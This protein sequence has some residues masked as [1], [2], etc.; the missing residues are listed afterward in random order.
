MAN[1][2]E[3]FPQFSVLSEQIIN[4]RTKK[5]AAYMSSIPFPRLE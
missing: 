4:E 1:K 5:L 3:E 2:P